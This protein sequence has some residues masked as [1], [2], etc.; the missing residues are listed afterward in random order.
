[1]LKSKEIYSSSES[2]L[3]LSIIRMARLF[4][5]LSFYSIPTGRTGSGA[6]VMMC[7]AGFDTLS[8]AQNRPVKLT[9]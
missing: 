4:S 1:M 2:L 3:Y 7:V 8:I 5:L 9:G 6:F